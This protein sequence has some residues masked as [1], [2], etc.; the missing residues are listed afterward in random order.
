M[1]CLTPS[2]HGLPI[3]MKNGKLVVPHNPIILILK[4][5]V[6]VQTYGE[7]LYVFW[8]QLLKKLI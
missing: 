8:M 2:V 3:K 1:T 7:L 6:Q 5:M 4:G